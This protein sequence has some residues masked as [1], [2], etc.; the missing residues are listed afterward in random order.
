MA[1]KADENDRDW[2]CWFGLNDNPQTGVIDISVLTGL[3]GNGCSLWFAIQHWPFGG[4]TKWM[5]YAKSLTTSERKLGQLGFL[6]EKGTF[7][8]PLRLSPTALAAAW[9]N[10]DFEEALAPLDAALD[11]L[12]AASALFTEILDGAKQT[13]SVA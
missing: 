13:L 4:K 10:D 1:P 9:E 8:L 11:T 7:R 5:N 12:H 3:C 2:Y 6:C